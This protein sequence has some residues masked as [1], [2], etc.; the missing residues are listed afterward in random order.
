VTGPTGT[1]QFVWPAH[2]TVISQGF[3]PS[4]LTFEPP[5][6]GFAHF[7]T[8]LDLAGALGTPVLAAADGVVVAA[9]DGSTGY[10]NHVILAHGNDVLS[11]YGHLEMFG[12]TVGQTVKQGQLIGLLG[13]TGNSTGPHLHFEVRVQ[14]QPVDPAPFLPALPPGAAGPS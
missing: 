4:T 3:G 5:Y 7:H 2:P 14:N 11:L 6:A 1:G 10:G 8:G 9:T 12:V 13:S